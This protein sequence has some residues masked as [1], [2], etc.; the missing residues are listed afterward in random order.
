MISIPRVLIFI[1]A[2]LLILMGGTVAGVSPAFA[3][4]HPPIIVQFFN[5]LF[6]WDQQT[7][8]TAA[9]H[10]RRYR[11]VHHRRR[12]P[13]HKIATKREINP[14]TLQQSLKDALAKNP[15]VLRDVIADF[16]R[17]DKV[18]RQMIVAAAPKPQLMQAAPK[19]A[20]PQPAQP[21]LTRGDIEKIVHDYLVKHP[22]V[23]EEAINELQKRQQ[24]AQS[25]KAKAMV[26]AHAQALF[27]SPDEVVLGDPSGKVNFVEFFDYNC[28]YC[29]HAMNDMLTLMKDDPK[30]R[31]VLKEFP[32]LGPGSVAA[33][34]VA[35]AVR[36]QDKTGKKYL[37]FHKKLLSA[38]GRADEASA[39]AVA[40]EIGMNMDLIKKD[41][42]SPEVQKTLKQDFALAEALGLNG[43]PSYVIGDDVM[44]GAVGL[45]TLQEKINTARCGKETC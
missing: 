8:A 28:P 41:V 20:P 30:L 24:A 34:K 3:K 42:K 37:E 33:A 26:K 17:H 5:S 31:V 16:V 14:A 15:T 13:K 2:A 19:A 4:E 23:I 29:K 10:R 43:T 44:V 45:K 6:G 27:N 9:K 21:V 32:V 7:H 18:L 11:I 1:S 22:E 39:L 12:E 25:D 38:R 40:K 35:I 36:M